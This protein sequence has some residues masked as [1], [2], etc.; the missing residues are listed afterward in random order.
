MHLYGYVDKALITY[1]GLGS[2]SH[3]L[4]WDVDFGSTCIYEFSHGI[5]M[6][7]SEKNNL[8]TGQKLYLMI[9]NAKPGCMI[10]T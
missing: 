3:M 4:S 9:D 10:R 2:Q 8:K 5:V 7:K 6:C 1:N